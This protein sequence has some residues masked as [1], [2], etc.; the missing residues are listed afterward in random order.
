MYIFFHGIG[1]NYP[2]KAFH[3]ALKI[4]VENSAS[5]IQQIGNR[6]KGCKVP[7]PLIKLIP[8][9]TVCYGQDE[10]GKIIK[11]NDLCY[12]VTMLPGKN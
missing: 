10:R 2:K 5:A 11:F 3:Y 12:A 9:H 7:P 1:S 6:K 8:L 4:C